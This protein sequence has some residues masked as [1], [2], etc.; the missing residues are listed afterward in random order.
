MA[1]RGM[2]NS[3]PNA[4]ADIAEALRQGAVVHAPNVYGLH[5]ELVHLGADVPVG[6]LYTVPLDTIPGE[7]FRYRILRE[8]IDSN[9]WTVVVSTR[10]HEDFQWLAHF[11][12]VKTNG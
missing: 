4:A 5:D 8:H 6:A 3:T 11:G 10:A 7:P 2:T 1:E 12:W 9:R